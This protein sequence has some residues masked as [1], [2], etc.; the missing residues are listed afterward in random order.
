[1]QATAQSAA[2]TANAT[3]QSETSEFL[4]GNFAPVENE[5][6]VGTLK[7]HGALPTELSGVL[8]RNGPNPAG[9]V[10][11]KHHWFVGDAMLHAI[12]I[13]AGKA[14]GYRNRYVRTEHIQSVLGLPAAPRSPNDTKPSVVGQ[15]SRVRPMLALTA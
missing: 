3:K 5:V 12:R 9:A 2:A 14:S 8:L 11:P 10:S 6:T 4:R 7:V 1:M 13:E 15:I